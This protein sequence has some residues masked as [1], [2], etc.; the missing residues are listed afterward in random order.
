MKCSGRFAYAQARVQARF[1][2]LPA[3][4]EWQRLA[5][6]RTLAAFLEE[7]RVGA[8]RAWIKGFSGQSN[9]HDLEAGVRI[10]FRETVEEVAAWVPESW[11]CAV[12]WTRWL[13]LLPLLA[14]LSRGG[15]V[16]PWVGRDP[17][18]HRLLG[19]DGALD[20][21][22]LR[23][24]G[25]G[26]LAPAPA[27]PVMAWELEWRRRQPACKRE[28]LRPMDDLAKL[29]GTHEALFRQTRPEA[30]W[31][32][33]VELR[34]R[35]SL[36]FHRRLLQPAGPFIFLMLTALDL[37]RLRAELVTRAIFAGGEGMA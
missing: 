13:I 19:D 10:L 11:R 31:G 12:L 24:A 8:L 21:D 4:E 32:L 7:A 5:A 29:L 36:L 28:L 33:R 27:D 18:L 25:A 30:T 1:A 9:T 22:R 16:P 14:H 35:L 37:E 3:D 34:S 26:P 2:R 6:A 20:P 15:T 17:F 23:R